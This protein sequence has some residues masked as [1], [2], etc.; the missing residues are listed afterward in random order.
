MSL[1]CITWHGLAVEIRSKDAL[2]QFVPMSC[3]IASVTSS[4]SL[5]VYSL[6][7]SAA[8]SVRRTTSPPDR[9]A[10]PVRSIFVIPSG[11][12]GQL[13]RTGTETD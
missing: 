7:S 6:L 4:S 8:P 9:R 2:G 13:Y 11:P 12:T 1:D 10:V 5:A 3:V